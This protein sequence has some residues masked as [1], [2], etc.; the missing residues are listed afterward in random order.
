MSKPP[1][2]VQEYLASLPD[3]RRRALK[4]IRAVIRKNLDQGYEEGIQYGMI[5]YYVP[6]RVYPDGYH[7]DPK[8]PLPF[9][10][11]ASQKN[12]MAIYLMG[13]YG[14]EEH[15]RWFREAWTKSG[16]RLD[17]GKACIRFK[18]LEDV[19]LDVVGEVVRRIPAKAYIESYEAN[20]KTARRSK[21]TKKPAAK[22][23]AKKK[24]TTK[25]KTT[26]KKTSVRRAR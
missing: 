9:A 22:K 20:V 15:E 25:K 3:D 13:I 26:K 2:T 23:A 1:A 10:G 11:L 16:K 17:M 6:H 14:S 18:K 7:C 4:A 24:T 21:S 12:H 5:G 19:P 8:Q